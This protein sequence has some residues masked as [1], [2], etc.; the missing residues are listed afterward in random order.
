MRIKSLLSTNTRLPSGQHVSDTHKTGSRAGS[1]RSQTG[2]TRSPRRPAGRAALSHTMP[3]AVWHT[4]RP[5]VS[6]GL[7]AAGHSARRRSPPAAAPRPPAPSPARPAALLPAPAPQPAQ[8]RPPAL[9]RRPSPAVQ[10][11]LQQRLGPLRM[12]VQAPHGGCGGS[13]PPAPG[14]GRAED[15]PLLPGAAGSQGLGPTTRGWSPATRSPWATT[16]ACQVPPPRP[17][18]RYQATEPG[19]PPPPS[20]PRPPPP[21]PPGATRGRAAGM[22]PRRGRDKGGA[23]RRGRWRERGDEARR[24]GAA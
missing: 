22:W 11:Q 8:P 23:G 19:P 10:L 18:A 14:P 9:T 17:Q 2:S 16:S 13:W 5:A 1:P 4:A 3:Q 24:G 6:T 20:P 15:R 21:R 7:G 12:A